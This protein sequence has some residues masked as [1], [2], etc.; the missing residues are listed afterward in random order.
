M[1]FLG[2]SGLP[3]SCESSSQPHE[4]QEKWFGD[5]VG[6]HGI[7]TALAGSISSSIFGHLQGLM[8]LQLVTQICEFV[9]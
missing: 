7:A 5:I 1:I 3:E 4:D 9:A 2:I 6:W 8:F